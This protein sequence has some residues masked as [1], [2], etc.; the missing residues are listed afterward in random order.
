M[1]AYLQMLFSHVFLA[2]VRPPRFPFSSDNCPCS[3]RLESLEAYID[4]QRE[5]IERARADIQTLIALKRDAANDPQA[6]AENLTEK[7]RIITHDSHACCH[8]D[9]FEYFFVPVACEAVE[10]FATSKRL[11]AIWPRIY[12]LGLA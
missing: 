1:V 3:L 6:F 5:I 10:H 8:T 2:N 11:G 9:G 4:V 7:V 12:R